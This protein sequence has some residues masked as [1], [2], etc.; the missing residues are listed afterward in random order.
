[1][2]TD[3]ITDMSGI[4][5]NCTSIKTLPDISKW[6]TDN[7]IN[8]NK[9]F[10]NCTSIESLPDISKWKNNNVKKNGLNFL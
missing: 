6:N 8:M 3:N 5:Y 9:I 2:E 7:V 10:Y 4:L 1:M